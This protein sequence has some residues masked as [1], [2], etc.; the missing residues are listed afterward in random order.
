MSTNPDIAI[1]RGTT[2]LFAD[3]GYP[4]AAERQTKPS[5]AVLEAMFS[6]AL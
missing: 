3:L 1:T 5:R 6:T 2:N 4:D